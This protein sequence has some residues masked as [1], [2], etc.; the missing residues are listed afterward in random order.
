MNT[1]MSIPTDGL[2]GLLNQ[3]MDYLKQRQ[4]LVAQNVA[5]ADAPGYKARDLVSFETALKGVGVQP[6][7]MAA[8]SAGHLQPAGVRIG[9]NYGDTKTG[10]AYETLP[11]GNSVVIE[12]QMMKLNQV[13]NDYALVANLNWSANAMLKLALGKPASA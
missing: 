5:N 10:N 11:D 12:E 3:R 7:Q 8:T 6:V 13:S 4:A 9:G 1:T 2:F